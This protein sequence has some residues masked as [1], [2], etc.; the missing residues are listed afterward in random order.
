MSKDQVKID[1][2]HPLFFLCFDGIDRIISFRR[3]F[4]FSLKRLK[5]F[6]GESKTL[7]D[8]RMNKLIDVTNFKY[9]T[10][11]KGTDRSKIF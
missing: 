6:L 8:E 10:C 9:C 5:I 4:R 11:N 1:K 3:S 2:F 7:L